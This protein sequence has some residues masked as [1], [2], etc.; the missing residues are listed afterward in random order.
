M[1][2]PRLTKQQECV[3]L[4]GIIGPDIALDF[5]KDLIRDSA[6][7]H[8]S[9]MKSKKIVNVKSALKIVK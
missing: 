3:K 9:V 7:T 2:K 8:S 4:L 1:S 6:V 5:L